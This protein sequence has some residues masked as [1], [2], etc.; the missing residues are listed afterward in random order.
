MFRHSDFAIRHF[1]N[2]EPRTLPR[3]PRILMC[4]P[5]FYGIHYEINPWM[6][7]QRQSDAPMA[8]RQW[9]GLRDLLIEAG[10]EIAILPPSKVCPT[11]S[12]PPTP[13]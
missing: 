8:R 12:S 9:E 7:R 13:R 2:P 10:A 4:P 1:L 6:S 11:W 5:D 3:M